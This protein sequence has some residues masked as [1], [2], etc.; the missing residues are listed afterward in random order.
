MKKAQGEMNELAS[1]LLTAVSMGLSMLS[2]I[3]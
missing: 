2:E 1:G 3:L